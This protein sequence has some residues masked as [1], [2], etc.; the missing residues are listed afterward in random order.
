MGPSPILWNQ[1]KLPKE[2]P[3]PLNLLVLLLSRQSACFTLPPFLSFVLI[4][5]KAK[6]GLSRSFLPPLQN[7]FHAGEGLSSGFTRKRAQQLA[8]A[9]HSKACLQCTFIL[10]KINNQVSKAHGLPFLTH[11]YIAYHEKNWAMLHKSQLYSQF[12]RPHAVVF[13]SV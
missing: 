1:S 3:G 8:Q 4:S 2:L 5:S 7:T 10:L 12:S 13:D 9:C 6:E 11:D